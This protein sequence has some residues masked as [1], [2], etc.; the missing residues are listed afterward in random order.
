MRK[1]LVP[2]LLLFLILG[3]FYFFNSR[4]NGETSVDGLVYNNITQSWEPVKTVADNLDRDTIRQNQDNSDG[5]HNN[6]LLK[7]YFESYDEKNQQLIIKALVPFT[8]GNLYEQLDLKLYTNQTIYCA[9]LNYTDPN[10]GK[11]YETSKLM[12]PVKEGEIIYL[13]TE[14]II[15]FDSFVAKSNNLTNLL[16][17]TTQNLNKDGDNYIQKIIAL[18]LCD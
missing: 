18:G 14:K 7:G 9:P 6:S 1:R 3:L 2:V 11:S 12:I 15:S 13:P 10:T 17:Q 8:Q 4:R 16:I 5:L